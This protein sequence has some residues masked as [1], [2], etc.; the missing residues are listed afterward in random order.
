MHACA[1]GRQRRRLSVNSRPAWSAEEVQATRGYR[2]T[3]SKIEKKMQPHTIYPVLLIH[4]SIDDEHLGWFYFLAA[5]NNT[6]IS[7][8]MTYLCSGTYTPEC[9]YIGRDIIGSYD[10]ST[11]NSFQKLLYFP[12]C[13]H[14]FIL[15]SIGNKVGL[16]K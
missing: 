14:K 7:C 2:D 9:K 4:L 15:H 8:I 10:V 6:V 1:P 5:I 12:W 11:L 16:W 13:F 3:V